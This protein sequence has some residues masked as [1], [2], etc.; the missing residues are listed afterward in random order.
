MSSGTLNGGA[1]FALSWRAATRLSYARH[2]YTKYTITPKEAPGG[3]ETMRVLVDNNYVI[4]FIIELTFQIVT[5]F[6][7]ANYFSALWFSCSIER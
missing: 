3:T 2:W 5:F 1:T 7:Q 6:C 4:S